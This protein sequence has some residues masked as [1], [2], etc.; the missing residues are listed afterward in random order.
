MRAV[1]LSTPGD[2]NTLTCREVPIPEIQ[3]ET[4]VRVRLK[5]ASVNPVDAKIRQRGPYLNANEPA[6]LG[7]DGAGIVESVGAGVRHF[8]PGDAVFF[9]SGGLGGDRGT[10]AD[11]AIVDESHLALKPPQLNFVEAAAV[12]L[13]LIAA[14]EALYDRAA[15]TAGQRVLIHGGAGGVG[16]VALQLAKLRGAVVATTVRDEAQAQLVAQLGADHCIYYPRIE[17]R[18][19]IRVWT[20]GQ[21]VDVVLD[22]VGEPVLSQSFEITRLG[23]QVITLL[24]PTAETNWA[25]ARTHNL[26]VGFELMLTPA[27]H[28]LSDA[29]RYQTKIL[30]SCKRWVEIGQFQIHIGHT[31]PLEAVADAHRW[32]ESGDGIGKTVLIIDSNAGDR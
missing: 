3:S 11:Y 18:E 30:E 10:Y 12:P 31:F 4:E 32:I 26:R 28:G 7:C 1:V 9:C 17:F 20:E 6:I 22:T 8:S 21:G 25:I 14:W 23:G 15:I 2:A 19:A 29:R 5:A 24:A 16:H 27:L 13:V